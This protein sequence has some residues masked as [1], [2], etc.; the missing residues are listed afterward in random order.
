MSITTYSAA[1]VA[2]QIGAPSQRWVIEQLR[3]GRFPG[4][5]IG[6]NWRLTE[7]DVIAALEVCRFNPSDPGEPAFSPVTGL[8]PTSRRNIAGV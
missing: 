6:R 4:R 2:E 8:T 3:S 5:K 1:E 7:E